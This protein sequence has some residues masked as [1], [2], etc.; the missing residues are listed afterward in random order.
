M[1][2]KLARSISFSIA[3]GG[4]HY[5]YARAILETSSGDLYTRAVSRYV[6]LGAPDVRHPSFVRTDSVRGDVTSF[7]GI[8]LEGGDR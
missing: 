2:E 5:I 3:D 6:D 7:T 4:R 8:V 1:G